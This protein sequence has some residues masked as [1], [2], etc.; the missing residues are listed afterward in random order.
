MPDT[1]TAETA[2]TIAQ[3]M[4]L[5][6]RPCYPRYGRPAVQNC[7]EH[8]EK[9]LAMTYESPLVR[10]V[11]SGGTRQPNCITRVGEI[12]RV[13]QRAARSLPERRPAKF[14]RSVVIWSK[15]AGARKNPI[16]ARP[17][18]GLHRIAPNAWQ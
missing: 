3:I 1:P 17:A 12:F 4:S 13:G 9:C 15:A 18:G 11:D 14:R 8:M 16:T 7:T 2:V 10:F 5:I 6:I